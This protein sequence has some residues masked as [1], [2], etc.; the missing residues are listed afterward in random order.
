M[1]KVEK[2]EQLDV[3]GIFKG[4]RWTYKIVEELGQGGYGKTYKARVIDEGNNYVVL[5]FLR[6]QGI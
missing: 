1:N 3:G 6:S 2:E 5:K 4:Q